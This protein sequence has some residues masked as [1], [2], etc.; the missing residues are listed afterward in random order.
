[1]IGSF[2]SGLSG[3]SCVFGLSCVSCVSG[4]LC[5]S[6]SFSSGAPCSVFS[7]LSILE[8]SLTMQC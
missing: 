2:W 8:T 3:V 4:I 5:V 6:S 1:M 7:V